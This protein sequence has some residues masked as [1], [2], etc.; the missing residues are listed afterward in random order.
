MARQI[1]AAQI[2]KMRTRA[3][4]AAVFTETCD[5]YEPPNPNTATRTS[6]GFVS[7]HFPADWT[8]LN[9]PT[10]ESCSI[11]KPHRPTQEQMGPGQVQAESRA[12]PIRF[13]SD[14]TGDE[15]CR[16]KILSSTFNPDLVGHIYDV[17]EVQRSSIE[18]TQVVLCNLVRPT[19]SNP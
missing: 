8:K 15:K 13:R 16:I 18:L 4:A 3:E 12:I 19:G 10:P 2:A 5:I 9:G 11:G 14:V 17:V 6:T 1:T 7:T